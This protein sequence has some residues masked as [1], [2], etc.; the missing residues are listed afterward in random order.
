MGGRWGVPDT[1]ALRA[2]VVLAAALGASCSFGLSGPED[3]Y[4]PERPPDCTTSRARPVADTVGAVLFGGVG[5][6][7]LVAKC[8]PGDHDQDV[9]QTCEGITNAFGVL[10][11]IPAAVYAVS[12][13]G[14]YGKTGRC[15]EAVRAH[16]E[17]R[18]R[19]A[20]PAR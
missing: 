13:A 1:K 7:F 18:A 10:L 12:A 6:A 14:G 5:L 11:L 9:D 3:G 2:V 4:S 19:R 8:G 16:Q 20:A 15:R 17:L